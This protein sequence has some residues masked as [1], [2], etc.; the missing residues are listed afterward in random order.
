MNF[1]KMLTLLLKNKNKMPM[2]KQIK[3][4]LFLK[5]YKLIKEFLKK[6]WKYRWPN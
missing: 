2:M 5:L 1:L 6:K 4:N 3:K